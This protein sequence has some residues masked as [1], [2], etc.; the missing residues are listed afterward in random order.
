MRNFLPPNQ[1]HIAPEKGFTLI[2][3]MIAI[4]IM[5][6]LSLI[7]WR[8]LD[9]MNRANTQLQLRSEENAQLMRTL[10]QIEQDLAWRTTVELP[11][12][13]PETGPQENRGTPT[14]PTPQLPA[15]LLAQRSGQTSLAFEVV[16]AAP[17]A[18]GHWQRVQW[19]R[20]G[21]TL[22]RAAGEATA[23]YPLHP[24][25]TADRIAALTGVTLFEIRAWEPNKGWR[26]I[27]PPIPPRATATG[28]E[29]TLA[30]RRSAGPAQQYR[31][32]IPLN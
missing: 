22:Y 21:D 13:L 7:T 16:R 20:Q 6:I 10:Q 11:S 25:Q 5:A 12:P 19:W 1:M 14:P 24:P 28:L 26:S 9:S 2:E 30:L 23:T 4:M 8:G 17:A 27:P 18:P 31:L 32:V 3:V 15:G 29:V